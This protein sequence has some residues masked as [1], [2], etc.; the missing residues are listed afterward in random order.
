MRV[1]SLRSSGTSRRIHFHYLQKPALHLAGEVNAVRVAVFRHAALEPW[2][3]GIGHVATC[4]SMY[5][6]L[7]RLRLSGRAMLLYERKDIKNGLER[8]TALGGV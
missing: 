3:E 2:L 7:T 6:G 8:S 4:E 1:S 5:S